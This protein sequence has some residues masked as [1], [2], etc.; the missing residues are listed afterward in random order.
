MDTEASVDTH[1]GIRTEASVDTHSVKSNYRGSQC[2][3][4][5]GSRFSSCGACLHA[6]TVHVQGSPG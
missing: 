6:F 1:G 5:R 4:K 3:S 2:M